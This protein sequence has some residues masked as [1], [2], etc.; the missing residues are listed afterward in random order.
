MCLTLFYMH[1]FMYYIPYIG[2]T[3]TGTYIHTYVHGCRN[4]NSQAHATKERIIHT[5]LKRAT[6][7]IYFVFLRISSVSSRMCSSVKSAF[8]S[9]L[10]SFRWA[11]HSLSI[12]TDLSMGSC[13]ESGEPGVLRRREG[14][15]NYIYGSEGGVAEGIGEH[16]DFHT[17]ALYKTTYLRD[18][19]T[20][21]ATKS[22]NT[23]KRVF[24]AAA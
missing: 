7:A 14:R 10:A 16:Q 5:Y 9:I 21:Q 4:R 23:N 24:D 20:L 8:S 17:T 6:S 19:Y 11:R 1:A 15:V 12:S 22:K 3:Y 18:K 13:L 2:P